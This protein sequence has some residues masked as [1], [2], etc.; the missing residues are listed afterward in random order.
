M[1]LLKKSVKPKKN[2]KKNQNSDISTQVRVYKKHT[3]IKKI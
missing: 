2:N 1:S 3:K